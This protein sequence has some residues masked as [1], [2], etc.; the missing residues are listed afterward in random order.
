M[1]ASDGGCREIHTGHHHISM[2][3]GYYPDH[4]LTESRG[5]RIRSLLGLTATDAWHYGQ[6]YL[7]HRGA[8]ALI[9]RHS[10]GVAGLHEYNP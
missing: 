5:V 4:S 8:T 3:G 10:G 9:Y 7:H 2:E 6:N 1:I